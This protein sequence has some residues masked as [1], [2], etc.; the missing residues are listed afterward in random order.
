MHV[1]RTA[2]DCIGASDT[3]RDAAVARLLGDQH[4]PGDAP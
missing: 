4:A 2:L 3:Q 1:P